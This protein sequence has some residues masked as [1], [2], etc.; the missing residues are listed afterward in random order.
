MLF[1]LSCSAL[2]AQTPAP[3]KTSSDIRHFEGLHIGLDLGGQSIFATATV[4][5]TSIDREELRTVAEFSLGHRWQFINDRV[6]FGLEVKL[7]L[8][9]GCFSG[10]ISESPSLAVSFENS[11][12]T[13]L[14]YAAGYVVSEKRRL[15][16]FTYLYQVRRNFAISIRE[17]TL[18]LE[19]HHDSH[20]SLRYGLGAEYN[21]GRRFNSLLTLGSLSTDTANP[22]GADKPIEFSLGLIYQF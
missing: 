18:L 20:T 7:G 11:S 10:S 13:S 1:I 8:T 12:Q 21:L 9:D 4:N 16:L 19:K 3:L 6:V 2:R 22:T 14:G 5:E 15:L 17:N